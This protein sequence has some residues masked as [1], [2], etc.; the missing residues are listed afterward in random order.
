[1]DS[2]R[3]H[4]DYFSELGILIDSHE[5]ANLSCRKLSCVYFHLSL[6]V[7][8]LLALGT[9]PLSSYGKWQQ[10]NRITS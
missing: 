5:L 8:G 1:M 10:L 3:V 4:K 2:F 7:D 9:L 6:A